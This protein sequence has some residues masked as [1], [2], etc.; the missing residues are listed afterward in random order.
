MTDVIVCFQV[1]LP[2]WWRFYVAAWFIGAQLRLLTP[3]PTRIAAFI[4]KH[5]TYRTFSKR[6]P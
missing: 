6:N 3:D 1:V 2:W 5:T 4:T